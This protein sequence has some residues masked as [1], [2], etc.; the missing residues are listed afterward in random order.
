MIQALREWKVL[1]LGAPVGAAASRAKAPGQMA[2][3]WPHATDRTA[4]YYSRY[5]HT[6]TPTDRPTDRPRGGPRIKCFIFFHVYLY[7]TA[8]AYTH[9]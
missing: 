1:L 3:D 2:T 4:G 5:A 9:R 6:C 7:C 8:C